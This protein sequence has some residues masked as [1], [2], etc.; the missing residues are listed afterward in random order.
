M[1]ATEAGTGRNRAGVDLLLGGLQVLVGLVILAHAAIATTLSLL[2]VGWLLFA[3]G[4][5]VLALSL[6]RIGKDRSWSGL[7]GGGLTAVLGVVFLRHTTAAAVTVTLVAGALWAAIGI[8]RLSAAYSYP[9]QRVSLLLS[10]LVNLVLGL[11]VLF[12]IVD[13]SYQLL[14][15]LLGLQVV[16]EGLAV[17][18]FGRESRRAHLDEQSTLPA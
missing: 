1:A 15:I 13:A 12:N 11:I 10:G 6:V 2:F 8:A 14:G 5:F 4:V 18:I 7:I 9:E 17:M 3:T 16:V